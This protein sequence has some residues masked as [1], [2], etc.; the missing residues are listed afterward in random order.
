M[1]VQGNTQMPVRRWR[2]LLASERDAAAL[3]S[4]LAEAET[5]ER[6]QIFRELAAVE[7][8]HAAHWESKLRSAGAKVPGPGR[9][10]LRTR[11]LGG[12]GQAVGAGCPAAGRA[13]RTSRRWHV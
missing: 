10:S 5:G 8:K 7:L 12:C 13:D 4:R 9:P 1:K 11:L 3:Y 2:G 6:Q